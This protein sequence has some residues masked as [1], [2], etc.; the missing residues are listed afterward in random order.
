M[1]EGWPRCLVE[2]WWRTDDAAKNRMWA[3]REKVVCEHTYESTGPWRG[4]C[5]SLVQ[6]HGPRTYVCA[7]VSPRLL[8]LLYIPFDSERYCYLRSSSASIAAGSRTSAPVTRRATP[9]NPRAS[10]SPR[11]T[12][13]F[14]V[15]FLRRSPHPS[16]APSHSWRSSRRSQGEPSLHTHPAHTLRN[17]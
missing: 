12:T 2:E 1:K 9:S 17:R 15:R 16:T 11:P 8:E 10:P 3:R 7:L 13:S 14:V 4:T 5:G 6:T